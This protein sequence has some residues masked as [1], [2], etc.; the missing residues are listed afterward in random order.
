MLQNITVLSAGQTIQTDGKSQPIVAPVVTLLVSPSQAEAL[1][2]ANIEGHIQLV[3]RN[4]TDLVT[5]ATRGRGLQDL[6]GAHPAEVAQASVAAP[7]P[8]PRRVAASLSAPAAIA[9]KAPTAA[10]PVPETDQIIMIR[11]AVKKVEV[12]A[13]EQEAK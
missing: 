1:A 3:L 10:A 11:G 6:Y 9:V 2:L 8:K 7:A 12:F 5:V 13:R 4:S